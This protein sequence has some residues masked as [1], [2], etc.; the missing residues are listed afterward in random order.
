MESVSRSGGGGSDKS[1]ALVTNAREDN[2]SMHFEEGT[3][4]GVNTWRPRG[5]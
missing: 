1:E 3:S 4:S 5:L 2:Q